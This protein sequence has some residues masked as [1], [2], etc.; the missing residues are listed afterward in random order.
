MQA[1]G[2]CLSSGLGGG[3]AEAQGERGTGQHLPG[4]AGLTAGD[5]SSF[6][7]AGPCMGW[8][9]T[10]P[11]AG[12]RHH[13][14]QTDLHHHRQFALSLQICAFSKSPENQNYSSVTTVTPFCLLSLRIK[15][16][17]YFD[18]FQGQPHVSSPAMAVD[19]GFSCPCYKTVYH[20]FLSFSPTSV[21]C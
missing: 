6:S 5:G 4:D 19:G 3:A 16:F 13:P 2:R 15:W 8:H 17:H 20:S 14:M 1:A 9:P 18:F 7:L 12:L 11:S 10:S 21:T